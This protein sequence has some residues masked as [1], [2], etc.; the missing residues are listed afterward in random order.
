MEWNFQ[1]AITL[2]KPKKNNVSTKGKDKTMTDEEM[3]ALFEQ[4]PWGI[5]VYDDESSGF[6][7]TVDTLNFNTQGDDV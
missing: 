4:D 5:N 7:D 1:K 2:A 3:I 6:L